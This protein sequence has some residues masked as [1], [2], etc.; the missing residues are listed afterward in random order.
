MAYVVESEVVRGR[1]ILVNFCHETVGKVFKLGVLVAI[2]PWAFLAFGGWLGCWLVV[3]PWLGWLG[4]RVCVFLYYIIRVIFNIRAAEKYWLRANGSYLL[5]LSP[6]PL[7]AGF[8]PL[9]WAICW[10]SSSYWLPVIHSDN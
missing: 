10:C 8:H 7:G 3:F 9:A 2:M 4:L 5:R 1:D 6:S